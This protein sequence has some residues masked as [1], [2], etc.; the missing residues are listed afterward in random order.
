VLKPEQV[1]FLARLDAMARIRGRNGRATHVDQK[2]VM[3]SWRERGF[4][5]GLWVDLP[6]QVLADYVHD[7]EL[8]MVVEDE[9]DGK[10]HRP[11][12]GEKLLIPARAMGT[13]RTSGAASRAGCTDALS[14]WF[15]PPTAP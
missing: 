13:V 15:G 8:V 3:T 9:V 7:D 6:G 14:K 4:S 2:A 5:C 10:A 11:A 1:P 12:P